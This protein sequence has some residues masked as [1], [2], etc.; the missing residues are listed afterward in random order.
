MEQFVCVRMVQANALDLALFQFD[1]DL[2][3][4]AFFMNAD[5]TIYGRYG[6]R[7]S[8]EEATRD[9]SLKGFRKSLEAALLVHRNLPALRA[10]LLAKT[11][12]KPTITV[13]EEYAMLS[14]FKPI[15][16][17]QGA[18]AK[19]CLHCRSEEHTS[20]LQSRRNLVCRL[21]LEKKKPLPP[22]PPRPPRLCQFCPLANG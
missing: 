18:V 13:P 15:L 17:Y 11:G 21:L 1:F 22:P 12:P 10:S 14:R 9:I 7:S 20:E 2:T 16:D 5:K 19:S 8:H 4:A 6:T 3:F